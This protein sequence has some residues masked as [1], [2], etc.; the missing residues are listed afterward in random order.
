MIYQILGQK[1]RVHLLR[2]SAHKNSKSKQ[3]KMRKMRIVNEMIVP[4]KTESYSEIQIFEEIKIGKKSENVSKA[5]IQVLHHFEYICQGVNT[6]NF[7]RKIEK[8]RDF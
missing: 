2:P 5:T 7:R 8:M 1:G 6:E 4:N 3:K